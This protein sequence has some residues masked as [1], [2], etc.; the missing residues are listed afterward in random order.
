MLAQ[1][2]KIKTVTTESRDSAPDKKGVTG[3]IFLISQ[4]SIKQE[5]RKRGKIRP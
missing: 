2:L 5:H 4:S 3:I 1:L